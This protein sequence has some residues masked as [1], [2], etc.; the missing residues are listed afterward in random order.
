MYSG[1]EAGEMVCM[2]S[3][4]EGNDADLTEEMVNINLDSDWEGEDG[5]VQNS[6]DNN[7]ESDQEEIDKSPAKKSENSSISVS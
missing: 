3:D 6:E 5:D 1:Q 4:S 7:S 2:K